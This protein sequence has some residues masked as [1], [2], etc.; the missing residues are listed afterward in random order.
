MSAGGE[1]NNYQIVNLCRNGVTASHYVHR[2][3]ALAYIPNP[4]NYPQV[5]HIDRHKDHNWDTNLEWCSAAYNL[6]YRGGGRRKIPVLCIELNKTYP[7]IYE[8]AIALGGHS[9]NLH[10]CIRGKQK[11]FAGYHWQV[12]K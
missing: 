12:A 8:A 9:S 4:H 5:N 6:E 7:S 3:V 11:T 10:N 1:P 2:L